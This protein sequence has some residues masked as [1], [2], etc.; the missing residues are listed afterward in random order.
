MPGRTPVE[1]KGAGVQRVRFEYRAVRDEKLEALLGWLGQATED[2]PGLEVFSV[3][4]KPEAAGW[5][6]DVVFTR[7]E[8]TG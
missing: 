4:I 8:R 2:I 5:L 3:T 1:T 7:W 6:M